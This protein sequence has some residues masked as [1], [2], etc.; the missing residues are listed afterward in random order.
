MTSQEIYSDIK[1]NACKKSF[2]YL[3]SRYMNLIKSKF[4]SNNCIHEAEDRFAHSFTKLYQKITLNELENQSNVSGYFLTICRNSFIIDAQ[5]NKVKPYETLPEYKLNY[6]F[7]KNVINETKN[8]TE[9]LI[10]QLPKQ[11]R[12]I[13]EKIYLEDKDHKEIAKELGINYQNVRKY[14]YKAINILKG[15]TPDHYKEYI[16]NAA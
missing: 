16:G 9:M 2:K 10:N 1:F 6:N 14:Q 8:L 4:T 3:Q 15:K 11:L 12:I 13:S 5:R 7:D